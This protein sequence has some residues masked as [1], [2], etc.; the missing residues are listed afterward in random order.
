MFTL[1]KFSLPS[2]TE[3]EAL[4]RFAIFSEY[5]YPQFI[6]WDRATWEPRPTQRKKLIPWFLLS[7]LV[8]I[9]GSIYL[10]MLIRHMASDK[11]DAD[12]TITVQL[13]LILRSCSN[14][15]ATTIIFTFV[16]KVNEMCFMLRNLEKIKGNG[17]ASSSSVGLFLHGLVLAVVTS[18]I[19]AS[20]VPLR[21]H[22]VDGTYLW[23]RNVSFLSEKM[24]VLCRILI[25]F[26]ATLH[27]CMMIFGCA[28]VLTN[29]TLTLNTVL[30]KGT[31]QNS[32]KKFQNISKYMKSFIKYRQ[33]Q[34]L[35]KVVNEVFYYIIPIGL[36][37]PFLCVVVMGYIAIKMADTMPHAVTFIMVSVTVAIL[38]LG[39][40][41]LPLIADVTIWG[42]RNHLRIV[43]WEETPACR[44]HHH[45]PLHL[46][47]QSHSAHP[48]PTTAYSI[49]LYAPLDANTTMEREGCPSC[50]DMR[51]RT[52]DLPSAERHRAL[53]SAG[54]PAIKE[55]PG[56]SRQD[57]KRPDGLTLIPWAR[58]RPLVWDFT[59]S[60]TFAPSYLPQTCVHPG[61]AAEKAEDA[62]NKKYEFLQDRLLFVPVAIETI[63]VWGKEGLSLIKE[64]GSRITIVTEEK[65]ATAFLLQRMSIA[66]QRGNVAA[67]LG[68]LPA[69][70]ELEEIFL[71]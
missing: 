39:H 31:I 24:K 19:S 18:T 38:G 36:V 63:G 44:K 46:R 52:I 35:N 25:I 53:R 56:C 14:S 16:L 47:G 68:S 12:I 62:K 27:G 21:R 8:A 42:S 67:I 26:P 64:I 43:T 4:K 66:V 41:V 40:W 51:D 59:C 11:K 60:D 49:L 6:T 70:R 50:R 48:L 28:N 55:P 29:V 54:A 9:I 15:V 45:S 34:V 69:G 2:H 3:F 37:L 71:L 33:L 65:R 22:N 57:G 17:S 23:F 58:G 1:P 61:A 32:W 10:A 7:S 30:K 5:L 13:L 20:T